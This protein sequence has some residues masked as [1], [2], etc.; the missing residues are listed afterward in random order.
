M[1][2]NKRSGNRNPRQKAPGNLKSKQ[3][4]MHLNPRNEWHK[5]ALGYITD[6]QKEQLQRP[7]SERLTLGDLFVEGLQALAGIER[8][9]PR[10]IA[11]AED[12]VQIHSIVQYIM[13]KLESGGFAVSEGKKRTKR[14]KQTPL[15]EGMQATV[16]RYMSKGFIGSE[17]L[18]ED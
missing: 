18:D 11:S 17:D 1:P 16:D 4:N 10:V 14:E 9:E 7:D 8:T 12:V 15:S 5:W 6:F 2:G 13:D 3:V